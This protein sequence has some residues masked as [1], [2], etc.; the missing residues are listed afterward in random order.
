MSEKRVPINF[1]IGK[2]GQKPSYLNPSRAEISR[3]AQSG[4]QFEEPN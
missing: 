2:F 4:R 1:E 3:K